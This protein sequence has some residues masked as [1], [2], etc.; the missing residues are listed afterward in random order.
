MLFGN[1]DHATIGMREGKEGLRKQALDVIR[2]VVKAEG[3]N[4]E[5]V[6]AVYFTSFV[7]Q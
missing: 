1:Q 4:P 2:G 6:E 5:L 3:G 7:M